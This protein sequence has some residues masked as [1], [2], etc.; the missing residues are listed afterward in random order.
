MRSG[1]PWAWPCLWVYQGQACPSRSCMRQHSLQGLLQGPEELA[2]ARV[3]QLAVPC[4]A[5]ACLAPRVLRTCPW[6]M[7]RRVG[8]LQLGWALLLLQGTGMMGRTLDRKGEEQKQ[9]SHW[10]LQRCRYRL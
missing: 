10:W 4:F 8:L 2:E 5:L 3:V 1:L 9:L 6:P 7:L